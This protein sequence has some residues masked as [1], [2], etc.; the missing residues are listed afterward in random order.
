[1]TFPAPETLLDP[2]AFQRLRE[3]GGDELLGKIVALF[4]GHAPTRLE[5]VEAGAAVADLQRIERGAHALKSSAANVGGVALQHL[6]SRLEA[7]A[8]SGDWSEV[9]IILPPFRA[10]FH[11][12]LRELGESGVAAPNDSEEYGT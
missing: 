6:A 9:N 10:C 8:A 11:D 12:T 4:L 1:M 3:W 2:A 5:E 7:A